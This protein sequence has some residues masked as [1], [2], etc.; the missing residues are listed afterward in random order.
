ME[1]MDCKS[2]QALLNSYLD[3]DL[4]SDVHEQVHRHC[5]SCSSCSVARERITRAWDHLDLLAEA[6]PPATLRQR[7][8]TEIRRNRLIRKASM[9][10]PIAAALIII[11]GYVIF[12]GL[13][14]T[15]EKGRLARVADEPVIQA[16]A[17]G[18]PIN[19]EELIGN[20]QILREQEFFDSIDTLRKIDYLPL[21]DD[22]QENGRERSELPWW[23]TT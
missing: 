20:L 10:V 9:I 6:S 19:E 14:G 11:F 16:A 21:V 15:P 18:E 3:G 23:V 13:P 22:I 12:S 1:E 2:V 7:V 8:L 4:V 17:E 5:Q